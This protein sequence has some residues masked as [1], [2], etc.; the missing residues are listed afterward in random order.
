[1]K[2]YQQGDVVLF[3]VTKEEYEKH[4]K[5][6][7]LVLRTSPNRHE[8]AYGEETGHCHGIYFKDMLDKAGVTVHENKW[9]RHITK[10]AAAV[11]VECFDAVIKHEEHNPVALPKGY[12]IQRIVKEY[13]PLSGIVRNVID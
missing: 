12:Y 13:D 8:L 6:N 3:Q 9:S 11:M 10:P 1:M 7:N 2:K 4:C 5:D